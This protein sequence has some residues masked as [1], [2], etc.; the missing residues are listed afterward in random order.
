MPR[1]TVLQHN[2]RVPL[3]RF[4]PWLEAA[5]ATLDVVRCYAGDPVPAV[6]ET[7]DGLL[8]LGGTMN[9]HDDAGSPWLPAVRTLLVDAVGAGLPTLGICLG[10]QLMGV[11]YGGTVDVGAAPG[12]ER[13]ATEVRWLDGA[14]DDPVL[15]PAVAA[16]ARPDRAW[17]NEM[18]HD[19][20]VQLPD[21]AT[22]LASS[23]SFAIQAFRYGSAL[24]VQFHPEAGV[25]LIRR[26]A[27]A[28]RD[29]RDPDAVAATSADHDSEI[30]AVGEALAT[31]FVDEI[32]RRRR[33]K[34]PGRS[35]RL[36]APGRSS[37]R[38]PP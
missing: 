18:H 37:P 11:A 4:G 21:G 13:G 19:A 32:I 30:A 24:A 25:E 3:D 17:V 6:S 33:G 22:L 9:A 31:A 27:S 28:D 38:T 34:R 20:V 16:G 29:V 36:T 35:G 5:G 12:P 2:E 1:I 14:A 8:V 10:H 23:E 26:W 7:G 15:G